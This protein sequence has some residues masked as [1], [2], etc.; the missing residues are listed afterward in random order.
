MLTFY[1]I[2]IENWMKDENTEAYFRSKIVFIN[3]NRKIQ[4]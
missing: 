2:E 1:Y 4:A 3:G